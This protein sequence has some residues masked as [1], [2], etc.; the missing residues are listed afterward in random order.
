MAKVRIKGVQ[1]L[2]FPKNIKIL[3]VDDDAFNLDILTEYLSMAGYEVIPA[4]DGD[5]ALTKLEQNPDI[6]I[7]ILDRM[8]PRMDG[9][10]VLKILKSDPRFSDI[11]VIMQTAVVAPELKFEAV[12]LG[13]YQ[14][15]TKPYQDK[16]LVDLVNSALDSIQIH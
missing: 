11:P 13:V 5:V 9:M 2:N 16:I 6:S 14:Y 8:M 10:A 1:M 3:A 15:L 7:I 4:D 12:N